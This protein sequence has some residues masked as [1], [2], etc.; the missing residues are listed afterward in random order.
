MSEQNF[1]N[2]QLEQLLSDGYNLKYNLEKRLLIIS[3]PVEKTRLQNELVDC[4]S[5]LKKWELELNELKS[6][7]EK[8]VEA[9]LKKES[10]EARQERTGVNPFEY[11]LP[12]TPAHFFG[13]R[14]QLADVKSRIG[15]IS[16]QCI[17]I[18]GLRRSGKTSLLRYIRERPM[19]FCQASQ[20]PLIIYLD[21]QSE[22]YHTPEG[23]IEGLRREIAKVSGSEPWSR[24][25]NGDEYAV[26]D[27]LSAL[28]DRGHRLIVLID[29][30]ERISARLDQF[31]NWGE[32]WRAKASAGLLAL[33]V[34]SRRP[35][36]EIYKLCGLTSP[37]GNIFN[38]TIL[39]A[40]E[41]EEWQGLVGK[42]F[43]SSGVEVREN[44]LDFIEELTGGQPFY[45]Q[46]VA[47]LLWQFE[48]HG[49]VY[50]EFKFQAEP[51]FAS[52]WNELSEVERRTI[53]Q[54]SN[55]S[56]GPGAGDSVT[57][58]LGLYG[59][60]KANGQ[61]FSRVFEEYVRGLR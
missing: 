41:K 51:I 27:G 19:E 29:E 10:S 48:D 14:R 60:L 31:Q 28:R 33:V 46:M 16:A 37:F 13:R 17:S 1:R 43:N 54:I 21:F 45:T 2:K 18:V 55:G 12:V 35:L 44:E 22:R 36:A 5:K 7:S 4:D 25:E 42:G 38:T 61:V 34:A 32:D 24:N 57:K 47:A 58:L 20:Q 40:L 3:D 49:K 8:V 11:G 30:F 26:E 56:I 52:L 23:V 6:H 39:G 50:S 15:A 53:R 9:A 59:L